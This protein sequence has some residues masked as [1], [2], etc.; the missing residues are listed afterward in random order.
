[1]FCHYPHHRAQAPASAAACSGNLTDL[2]HADQNGDGS[3]QPNAV[4]A[5]IRSSLLAGRDAYGSRRSKPEF[6]LLALR[7]AGEILLPEP[8]IW[9]LRQLSYPVLEPGDILAD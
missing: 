5:V 4:D 3:R 2:G 6:D 7:Q 1:M 9:V 8:L